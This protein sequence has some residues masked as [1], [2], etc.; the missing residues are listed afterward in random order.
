MGDPDQLR[1]A[2]TPAVTVSASKA[3]ATASSGPTASVAPLSGSNQPSRT[4]VES[5]DSGAGSGW[6]PLVAPM[7]R[8]GAHLLNVGRVP[9]ICPRNAPWRP[10]NPHREAHLGL[11]TES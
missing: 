3:E 5:S 1:S 7:H 6:S 11:P 9:L 8:F 2:R 10:R 4:L